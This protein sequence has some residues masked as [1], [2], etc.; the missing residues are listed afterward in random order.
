MN[1]ISE[2][3]LCLGRLVAFI[4]PLLAFLLPLRFLTSF[5]SFVFRKLLHMV[6]VSCFTVMLLFARQWQAASMTCLLVAAA[7]YPLLAAFEEKSWYGKLF[8]EKSPGEVK[9][10]LLML[11][12]LFAALIAFTWG[13]LSRRE[14]G[15]AAILMWGLGDAM[16]ALMGI[17]FGRH[18]VSFPPVNG[19]KSWEGFFAMLLTSALAGFG[20]LWHAGYPLWEAALCSLAGGLCG[21]FTELLSP[22]EW[23]TV[24]VPVCIVTVILLFEK[25]ML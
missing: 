16:A 3:L 1:I 19:K 23:D 15:A 24:T 25:P 12:F 17:P 13:L 2:M 5:P 10:S 8:V 4:L 11:F 9:R 6:A 21:A 7:L 14:V 22:S 18:K 20:V